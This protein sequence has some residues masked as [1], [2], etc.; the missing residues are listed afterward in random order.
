MRRKGM[1]CDPPMDVSTRNLH[2]ERQNGERMPVLI[3]VPG[4]HKRLTSRNHVTCSR[5]IWGHMY[6]MVSRVQ[7]VWKWD[8]KVESRATEKGAKKLVS[9]NVAKILEK[10][11]SD[12]Y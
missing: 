7:K 1:I 6:D 4:S 2:K 9:S 11:S 12:K 5:N 8:K 3:W 10:E